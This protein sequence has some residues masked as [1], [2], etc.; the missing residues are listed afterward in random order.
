MEVPAVKTE[1][2]GYCGCA[3]PRPETCYKIVTSLW[4]PRSIRPEHRW[5]RQ[6]VECFAGD[7]DGCVV[8]LTGTTMGFWSRLRAQAGREFTT[9]KELGFCFKLLPPGPRNLCLVFAGRARWFACHSRADASV[10][11]DTSD[12]TANPLH[13]APHLSGAVCG[14]VPTWSWS[15]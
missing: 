13:Q 14:S 2:P 12:E 3:P 11:W 1:L 4:A 8:H 7:L 10:S 5:A 6:L 9:A 15:L